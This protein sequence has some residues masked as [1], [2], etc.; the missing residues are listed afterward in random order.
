M[1]ARIPFIQS[2]RDFKN[3]ARKTIKPQVLIALLSLFSIGLT[4]LVGCGSQ[5]TAAPSA[6]SAA[7]R[8]ALGT[9]DLEGTEEAVDAAQ[10]ARLLPL[11]QLLDELQSSGYAAPAEIKAVIDE[12]ET[13]MAAPQL[14]AIEA[15]NLSDAEVAKATGGTSGLTSTG[16]STASSQA[17]A[18]TDPMLGGDPGGGSIPFD[19]GGPMGGSMQQGGSAST[20]S[21]LASEPS[22]V[23]RVIQL[24][25]KKIQ[26]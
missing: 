21:S 24:L 2:D 25:Q 18:A 9:L 26:D 6:T 3:V 10:A 8:L 4:V 22:L 17:S 5:S 12:I 1:A 19:G 13:E 23:E 7:S 14:Q 16:T 20:S 15:M 11:W